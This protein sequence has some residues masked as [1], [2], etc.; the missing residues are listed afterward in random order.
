MTHKKAAVIGVG[1]IGLTTAILVLEQGYHVTI[2]SDKLL[3]ETTSMKAAASFKPVLVASNVLTTRML[4]LS[5]EYFKR[6]I[7]RSPEAGV[8]KH[9]HWEAMSGPREPATYLH[10]MEEVE[11]I[12]RPHVPGGYPFGWRYCT[13]FIDTA[14]F[15]PWLLQRFIAGGGALVLLNKPFASLEQLA[16]LPADIVFNC[17]GLGARALC[18]D[19]KVMAIKG[20]VALTKPQPEIDWSISADGFYMYPRRHNTVLGG[21]T[22]WQIND[23]KVD[24]TAIDRIIQ[25]NQRILPHIHRDAI[26]KTYAGLRPY[27]AESIRLESENIHG[28][29]IIHNYG[30]GG[31]GLTLCWG[32]AHLALQLL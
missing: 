23:E 18:R 30:H 16:E 29:Q 15:L 7:A 6:T 19:N 27:R 11:S 5:S 1:A 3:S 32:S 17:T 12:K 4:A 13:F 26:T 25:R 8:R 28:K 10:Y 21:T 14:L 24:P 2:Y 31:A 20:Q 9:I 22:E